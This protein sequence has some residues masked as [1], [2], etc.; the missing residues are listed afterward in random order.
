MS[1]VGMATSSTCAATRQVGGSARTLVTVPEALFAG[2]T[3]TVSV[4]YRLLVLYVYS[5]IPPP[6]LC[7]DACVS[8]PAAQLLEAISNCRRK[9][10]LRQ[11]GSLVY[12]LSSRW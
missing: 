7:P 11:G 1:G 8:A 12:M 6:I 4:P 3:F 9:I 10:S 5:R 2:G